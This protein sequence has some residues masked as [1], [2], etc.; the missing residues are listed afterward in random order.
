M[1]GKN[2]TFKLIMDGDSKGL[3]AAAKQSEQ[4]VSK[5]FEAIKQEANQTRLATNNATQGIDQLGKESTTAAVEVKKLDSELGKT[6]AELQKNQTFA[7]QASGEIQGL[8]TGYTALTSAM[9]ALGIGA[10]ATEIARTADEFKVLEARIG[11]VTSKS[12]NFTQAFEGVKKIAIETRSNL[13]ATAE[14]FTRVKTATD[15]LGYS[16]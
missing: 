6:N 12:G 7:K 10:S 1:S 16:Q 8:K 13:T 11:L 14:L 9:A 4:V 3:V 15:Q 5:V 2:L